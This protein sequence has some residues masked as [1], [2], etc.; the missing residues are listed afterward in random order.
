MRKECV[1]RQQEG[2]YVDVSEAHKTVSIDVEGKGKDVAG[3]SGSTVHVHA[4]YSSV[5]VDTPGGCGL[6][7]W[8]WREPAMYLDIKLGLYFGMDRPWQRSGETH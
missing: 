8:V 5:D 2:M 3:P 6:R 7:E 1:Q 4:G